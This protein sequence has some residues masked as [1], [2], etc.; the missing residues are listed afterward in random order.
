[1]NRIKDILSKK[2]FDTLRNM[3]KTFRK[4]NS[5]D[6]FNKVTK[7][8]FGFALK[9]IGVTLQKQDLDVFLRIYKNEHK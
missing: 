9:E 7:D 3:G 1:M 2:G 6:G 4:M 8:D 5:Y